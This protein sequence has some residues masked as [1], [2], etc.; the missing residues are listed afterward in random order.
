MKEA[1]SRKKAHKAVCWNNTEENKR[2]HESVKNKINKT[3]SKAIREKAE[4]ALTELQNCPNG[5]SRL[6]RG[7]KTDSK[8]IEGGRCMRDSDGK[9]CFSEKE[10]GKSGRIIWKGS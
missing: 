7:L 2:R 5:M 4:E 9:L 10:R 3:V 1:V 6:V 8:E